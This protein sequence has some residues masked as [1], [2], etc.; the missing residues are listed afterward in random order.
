MLYN[1]L[2]ENEFLID[3]LVKKGAISIDVVTKY[4]MY[5]H[6]EE[7]YKGDRKKKTAALNSTAVKYKC[8]TKTV[9]RAVDFM[10]S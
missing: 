10:E 5:D 6:F 1:Y 3:I 2:K 8:S 7:L 9:S 4:Q